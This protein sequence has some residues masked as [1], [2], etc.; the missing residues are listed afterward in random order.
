MTR[1]CEVGKADAPAWIRDCPNQAVWAW[2]PAPE[3]KPIRLCD[4]HAADC[5]LDELEEL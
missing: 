5:D 4:E 3:R 2:Y 1:V